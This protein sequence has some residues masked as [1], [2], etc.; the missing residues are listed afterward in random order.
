MWGHLW[1]Y[2]IS[3][4]IS[5][6]AK[7]V[8]LPIRIKMHRETKLPLSSFTW[9]W[10][11]NIFDMLGTFADDLNALFLDIIHYMCVQTALDGDC[12]CL[13]SDLMMIKIKLNCCGDNFL[14]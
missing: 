13:E 9:L 5:L 1:I 8:D 10:K 14:T 3:A 11:D 4:S 7:C 2:V 12:Y 6:C